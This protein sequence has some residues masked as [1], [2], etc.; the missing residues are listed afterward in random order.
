MGE[1]VRQVSEDIQIIET[2]ELF[3]SIH[4]HSEFSNLRMRD[5]INKIEDMMD[6]AYELGYSGM[7]LTD[8]EALSG[9]V[10]GITHYYKKYANTKFKLALGNE[11]YLVND[12]EGIKENGG[13]Y[14]HFILLAKNEKG[15]RL[16][17][18]LSTQAWENHFVSGVE[19]TPID[20][21]QLE[22]IIGDNKGN[23][24]A[25]TAC[26]GGEFA[27]LVTK[28]LASDCK[29]L[30]TKREIHKFLTWC[31]SIFGKDNFYIEL[32][33]SLD[34]EQIA[35]N[36]FAINI[37]EAYRLKYILATD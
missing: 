32:A 37:A 3:F 30:D 23:I 5:S 10:R 26:L 36:K 17:R 6:R 31:V 29:D 9:A 33:P 7:A 28:Y 15:W 35:F 16:L 8:H 12:V 27:Q 14:T 11:I 18:E 25:S 22:D 19:R 1:V 24:I 2:D 13:K 21:K 20:K 34:E 4:N